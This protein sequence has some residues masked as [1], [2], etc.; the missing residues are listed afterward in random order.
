MMTAATYCFIRRAARS[1]D[2]QS[3]R[4]DGRRREAGVPAKRAQPVAHVLDQ[5][6]EEVESFHPRGSSASAN[7]S[8]VNDV[9]EMKRSSSG[10]LED[11]F[12]AA[13]SV[14]HDQRIGCRVTNRRQEHAL[15]DRLRERE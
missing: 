6:V 11:L 2:P 7:Q 5:R 15:A 3:Q 10:R 1:A 13:E 4:E 12:A 9:V 8:Y 14:R